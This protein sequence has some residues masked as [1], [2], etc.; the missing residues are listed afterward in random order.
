MHPVL[1]M[2]VRGILLLLLTAGL[3][4]LFYVVKE[5]LAEMKGKKS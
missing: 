5:T 1:T 2:F 4:I 3:V